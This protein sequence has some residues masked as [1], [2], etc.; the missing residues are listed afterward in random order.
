MGLWCIS[1]LFIGSFPVSKRSRKF[2]VPLV[3]VVVVVVTTS[4]E[5]VL[6]CM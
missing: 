3:V 4:T 5:L 1:S 6:P 2:V